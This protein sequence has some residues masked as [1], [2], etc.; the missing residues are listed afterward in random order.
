[1]E[2]G[3][4]YVELKDLADFVKPLGLLSNN[5]A[6][7]AI[8]VISADNKDKLKKIAPARVG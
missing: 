7:M 4:F 8:H 2:Y 1:M 3:S 5:V 6:E